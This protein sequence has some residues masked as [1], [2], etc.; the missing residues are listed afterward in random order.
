M[1]YTLDKVKELADGDEDFVKS[2]IGVFIQEV[3]QDV[4]KLKESIE[5]QDFLK[6]YQS[7][8]KIK[9]NVD[10][11]GMDEAKELILKTEAEAQGNKCIFQVESYFSQL[12]EIINLTIIELEVKYKG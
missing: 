10:L 9:S 1:N 6:I 11:F 8:H 5:E 7:A 4:K 3:P 12:E 2:V